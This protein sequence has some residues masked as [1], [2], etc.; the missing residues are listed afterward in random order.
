[1]SILVVQSKEISP[2][3]REWSL[4]T[5]TLRT[6]FRS[7]ADLGFGLST[8]RPGAT[9]Q[10]LASFPTSPKRKTVRT[11]GRPRRPCFLT[12]MPPRSRV[13]KSSNSRW[14]CASRSALLAELLRRTAADGVRGSSSRE[15]A[16]GKVRAFMLLGDR[17]DVGCRVA[18]AGASFS[19]MG[20]MPPEMDLRTRGVASLASSM[21]WISSMRSSSMVCHRSWP[22][23]LEDSR[24]I[25]SLRHFFTATFLRTWWPR[26]AAWMAV[27]AEPF[28]AMT[29]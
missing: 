20:V 9:Q 5:L 12:S 7:T 1:M 2:S 8:A 6:V 11:C 14:R 15:L 22:H 13:T 27:A 3:K 17:G 19:A 29:S 24:A 10:S 4:P 26:K 21:P 25:R 16:W 18:P 23:L 28:S